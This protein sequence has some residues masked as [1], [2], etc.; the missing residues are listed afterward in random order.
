MSFKRPEIL[1]VLLPCRLSLPQVYI[2]SGGDHGGGIVIRQVLRHAS[3]THFNFNWYFSAKKTPF[4]KYSAETSCAKLEL[5][6][7]MPAW[8]AREPLRAA[9]NW[10]YPGPTS[11]TNDNTINLPWRCLHT[12]YTQPQTRNVIKSPWNH[13]VAWQAS[14]L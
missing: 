7:W 4:A 13:R 6:I 9:Q 11:C 12:S 5:N 10:R 8:C 2:S 1:H 14:Y 3:A